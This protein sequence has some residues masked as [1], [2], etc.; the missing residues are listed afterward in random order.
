MDFFQWG[1]RCRQMGLSEQESLHALLSFGGTVDVISAP[2]GPND[3]FSY[4]YIE[5]QNELVPN[6]EQ[7]DLFWY[8]YQSI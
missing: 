5:G 3:N 8:G 1:L 7:R 4:R 2:A 6:V